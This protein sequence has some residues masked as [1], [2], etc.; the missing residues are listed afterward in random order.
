MTVP[1]LV[2]AQA[3]PRPQASATLLADL[4]PLAAIGAGNLILA[5]RV[6]YVP[7]ALALIGM[8][9]VMMVIRV[10]T[11][12]LS[13]PMSA[14]WLLFAASAVVGTYVSYD[15]Q[16]SLSKLY[17]ILGGIAL[18][19]VLALLQAAAARGLVVATLL[20]IC[21]GTALYFVTQTDFSAE[22]SKLAI[23]NQVGSFLH[24]VTPQF[25]LHTPHP[26]LIAGILLLGLPY[27]LALGADA[28]RLKRWFTVISMV[29]ISAFLLFALGMSTS[30]GAALALLI[31]LIAGGTL[32]LSLRLAR[33]AGLSPRAGV[34]AGINVLLVVLLV[35]VA[36]GGSHLAD[37]VL[38]SAGGVPRPKLYLQ[39]FKL[40]EDF[41]FTGGGLGAFLNTYAT[42]VLLINVPFLPHA[43]NLWL[44]VWFEQ[45]FAGLVAFCWL[46]VAYY[47]WTLR[48]RDRFDWLALASVAATTLMLLH[49]VDDVL[50]YFSRVIALMFVP[51][52]LSVA[53]L[54]PLEPTARHPQRARSRP[55][56]AM[57]A[58]A[59]AVLAI[60]SLVLARREPLAAQWYS[61][62]GALRQSAIE[63]PQVK[64]PHPTPPQVR[65]ASDLA[66]AIQMYELALVHDPANVTAH[67]RLGLIA[68]DRYEFP[69][70][71]EHLQVAYNSDPNN[72]AVVKALGYA[73]VW[74]GQ[75][76]RAE[77]L[78]TQISEAQTELDY[79]IGDWD[80]LGR[81]DLGA[82]AR[83]MIVRLQ[84]DSSG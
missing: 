80:K 81:S 19:Y 46:I 36:F 39:V 43:H 8:G 78:L 1:L 57:I 75:L 69:Q 27:S 77:P 74:T 54:E 58:A 56:L 48:R 20:S 60:L 42:Y 34:A 23:V 28:W 72:R 16:A 52:G 50:F 26:N 82:H 71:L 12:L 7:V 13:V 51:I 49:G 61:N 24:R 14:P 15:P 47:A 59:V 33:Q 66:P 10:R 84:H 6:D 70:A 68:L 2:S 83:E 29:A 65:R 25:G 44:E 22:P 40:A 38:S 4:V 63:L 62:L 32:W 67:T 17:L 45:G 11:R 79:F 73:Y 18:F 30:R 37:A 35:A 53:A 64:F 55:R 41:M 3:R 9:I 31:L 76:D 5:A 21:V